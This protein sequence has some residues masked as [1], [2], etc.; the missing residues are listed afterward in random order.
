MLLQMNIWNIIYLNC[1]GRYEVMID[2]RS[3][4]HKENSGQN[5]IWTNDHCNIGVV[6]YQLSYQASWEL[7]TLWGRNIPV[8]GFNFTT[9]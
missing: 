8:E 7:V 2:H 9:D 6:L 5:R 1:G 3:Y 4:R